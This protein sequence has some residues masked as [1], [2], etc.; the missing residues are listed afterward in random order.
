MTKEVSKTVTLYSVLDFGYRFRS[1]FVVDFDSENKSIANAGD[2]NVRKLNVV[3]N[4]HK[5]EFI[6]KFFGPEKCPPNVSY[7]HC[8]AFQIW[9]LNQPE[10]QDFIHQKEM[11]E[12]QEC[13]ELSGLSDDEFEM[14]MLSRNDAQYLQQ[15]KNRPIAEENTNQK[16]SASVFKK[17]LSVD[18]VFRQSLFEMVDTKYGAVI[19]IKAFLF[20]S[21]R[22]H[23]WNLCYLPLIFTAIEQNYRKDYF[24]DVICRRGDIDDLL[25]DLGM[26]Y[27]VPVEYFTE[28]YEED[29]FEHFTYQHFLSKERLKAV[30]PRL[31]P[32]V[33]SSEY[34]C[35]FKQTILCYQEKMFNLEDLKELN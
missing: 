9:F 27:H 10:I 28:E 21:L 34:S 11:Q 26:Q 12:R 15:F 7:L 2:L 8:V 17:F 19:G 14:A 4:C 31:F 13:P 32:T 22:N 25:G 23:Q 29:T 35:T 16:L 20:D 6:A 5:R 24:V 33:S 1:L 3:E 30:N 18:K